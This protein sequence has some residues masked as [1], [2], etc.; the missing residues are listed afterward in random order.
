M[1]EKG[2]CLRQQFLACEGCVIR[3]LA[4]WTMHKRPTEPVAEILA[5]IGLKYCPPTFE[6]SAF[7]YGGCDSQG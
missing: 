2:P 4:L 1:K 7:D 6:P 3:D 5:E